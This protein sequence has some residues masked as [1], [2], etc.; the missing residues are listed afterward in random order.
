MPVN[1]GPSKNKPVHATGFTTSVGTKDSSGSK[2]AFVKNPD[3]A[4]SKLARQASMTSIPTE[5]KIKSKPK[6]KFEVT[7][8]KKGLFDK[9]NDLFMRKEDRPIP[10]G[11]TGV[12]G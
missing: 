1:T 3:L 10:S 5:S 9:F 6:K 8:K 7:Q 4:G 2:F 12:R 11:I